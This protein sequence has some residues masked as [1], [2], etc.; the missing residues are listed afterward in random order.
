MPWPNGWPRQSPRIDGVQLMYPVEAN[1]V[2]VE[3]PPDQQQALRDKGWS[4]YTFLP[5]LPVA[6]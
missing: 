4:F 1:A 6:G 2:F 3:I 5:P